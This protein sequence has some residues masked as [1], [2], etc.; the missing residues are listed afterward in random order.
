VSQ[1]CQ[2]SKFFSRNNDDA[3][4]GA[5]IGLRLW[6][7]LGHSALRAHVRGNLFC[8]KTHAGRLQSCPHRMLL[9]DGPTTGK[10]SQ[11]TDRLQFSAKKFWASL[12]DADQVFLLSHSGGPTRVMESISELD[13]TTNRLEQIDKLSRSR[14]EWDL[15]R[16]LYHPQYPLSH[17][18]SDVVVLFTKDIHSIVASYPSPSL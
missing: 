5:A 9:C 7:G 1:G 12:V 18:H 4:A 15:S 14:T 6:L 13:A 16:L 11:L 10:N 3:G 2:G 8:S 17:D